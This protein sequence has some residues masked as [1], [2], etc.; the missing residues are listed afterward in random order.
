L[1]KII[2][3]A[4]RD[5][6]TEV[7]LRTIEEKLNASEKGHSKRMRVAIRNCRKSELYC[8]NR[9]QFDILIISILSRK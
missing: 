3:N 2:K 8:R 9:K 1:R 5:D 6:E 7:F 4:I